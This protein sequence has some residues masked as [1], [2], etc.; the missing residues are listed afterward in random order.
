LKKVKVPEN[1]SDLRIISLTAF[2][3]KYLEGF[4][5]DW[6]LKE[7][8][9]KIDTSQCGGL[10]GQS[11]SHYMIDLVNFVLYNQDLNNPHATLAI[12]YDFSKAFNRQEHNKLITILSDMGCPGWLLKL[13]MAF[14]EE[15][16]MTL[17]YRGCTSEEEPLPG[18]G[19]AGTKL[20]LF[21]FLV[22]IILFQT[23]FFVAFLA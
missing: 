10:K 3:L 1:K 9:H 22:L 20:G 5:L 4:I 13:V 7:I 15:R 23:R 11:T 8:G 6:L 16:R 14:L 18:G 19:P 2:W 12:M 17:K 21:L